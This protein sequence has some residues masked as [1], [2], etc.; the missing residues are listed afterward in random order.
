MVNKSFYQDYAIYTY[1]SFVDYCLI[2]LLFICYLF[3]CKYCWCLPHLPLFL[4]FHEML[5]N[6]CHSRLL[7]VKYQL[8]KLL[9]PFVYITSCLR[10]KVNKYCF[11]FQL[12]LLSRKNVLLRFYRYIVL[13]IFNKKKKKKKKTQQKRRNLI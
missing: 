5:L 1:C 6:T 11:K 12:F 10:K 2:F 4:L 13:F 8:Y 9:S 3:S 7:S